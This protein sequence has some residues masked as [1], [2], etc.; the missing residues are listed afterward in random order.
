MK[1]VIELK[2]AVPS[3]NTLMGWKHHPKTRSWKYK[4]YKLAVKE[5]IE[6][7]VTPEQIAKAQYPGP[8]KMHVHFERHSA[9]ELDDDNLRGGFKP[10]RD[11][12]RDLGIIVDDTRHWLEAEYSQV[13]CKKGCGKS[14]MTVEK[15][16]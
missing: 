2:E 6:A 5:E 11:C 9:G 14:V 1:L 15:A 3:L 12:L 10:A 4:A 7:Q 16:Q 8:Q 13:K